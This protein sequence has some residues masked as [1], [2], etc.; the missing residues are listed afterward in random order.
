MPRGIGDTVKSN[1]AMGKM[2][3]VFRFLSG[4]A[5]ITGEAQ[6]AAGFNRGIADSVQA[7][8]TANR[9]RGFI[10]VLAASV[11]AFESAGYFR[12]L[13]ALI[14]DC[15][16]ADD[17]PG[18][19]GDYLRGLFETAGI[20][21]ETGIAGEYCR[22][23]GDVVRGVS[24]LGR[25]LSVFIKLASGVFIHDFLVRRFLVSREEVKL[26]SAVGREIVVESRVGG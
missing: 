1:A 15:V 9:I 22:S 7:Q 3:S 11:V 4:G 17:E 24:S 23:V 25:A 20:E 14:A 2:L 26:K 6:R 5:G 16:R 19:T 8:T 10:R 12:S 18:H 13:L 21:T